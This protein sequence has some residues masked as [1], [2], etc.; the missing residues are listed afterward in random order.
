MKIRL[1]VRVA[2]GQN[3]AGG[4]KDGTAHEQHQQ[5]FS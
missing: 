3:R 5:G 4:I 1:N 2:A